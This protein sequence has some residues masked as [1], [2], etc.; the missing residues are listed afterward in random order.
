MASRLR[1]TGVVIVW[2]GVALCAAGAAL[3]QA[4]TNPGTGAAPTPAPSRP[5][6]PP[7][8]GWWSDA[9]FYEVFVR[10]FL[11]SREGPLAGDG[12]GDIAGLISKLDYLNDGDPA[13]DT[14][15]GITGIWLMPM[16]PSP[17]YHGYDVT[18]YFG[19]N[20]KYG[21]LDDFK[22]LLTEC[23]RRGIR[24]I[25]DLVMNHHSD[26]HDWFTRAREATSP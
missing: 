19:I 10:S 17:S 11:D 4:T 26:R 1:N 16:Q 3:G 15:L 12:I 20:P 25:I 21:T 22:R 24:V 2:L 9:V 8:R 6:P 23:R 18:D 7:Q 5:V 13:T 14:D